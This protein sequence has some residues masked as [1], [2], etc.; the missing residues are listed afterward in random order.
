MDIKV[1]KQ[2][3]GKLELAPFNQGIAMDVFECEDLFWSD[4]Y[5]E[6]FGT[7]WWY[8]VD[9]NT[10]LVYS[11]TDY[12]YDHVKELAMGKSVTLEPCGNTGQDEYQTIEDIE[13]QTTV[14]PVDGDRFIIQQF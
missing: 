11:M 7:E 1:I 13:D 9:Y 12:H 4:L 14:I 2:D 6:T 8:L 5:F 3:G 10:G